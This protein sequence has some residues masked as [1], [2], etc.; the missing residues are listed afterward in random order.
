MIHGVG[1]DMVHVPRFRAACDRFG[2]KLYERLFT[3]GELR[4]CLGKKAPARHLAARFAAKVSLF[5]ALGSFPG[6]RNVEV[7]S[8]PGGRPGLKVS[9]IDSGF[10]F[11]LAISHT[12][13]FSIAQTIVESRA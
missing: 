6:F 2:A 13:E 9:G 7:T 4:Y 11:S 1:I 12:K 3:A 10:T 8:G 5:K